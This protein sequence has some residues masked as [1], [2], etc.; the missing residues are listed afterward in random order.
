MTLHH[1]TS[2]RIATS[3]S[4]PTA[5]RVVGTTPT[6]VPQF[7]NKCCRKISWRLCLPPRTIAK[8]AGSLTSCSTLPPNRLKYTVTEGKLLQFV[9][10]QWRLPRTS[11]SQNKYILLIHE[12]DDAVGATTTSL[13]QHL[14]HVDLRQ[15][16]FSNACP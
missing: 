14:S 15:S 10:L 4:W 11:D 7:P 9:R 13:E 5:E 8:S 3:L 1:G 16:S 2:V 12:E 6:V